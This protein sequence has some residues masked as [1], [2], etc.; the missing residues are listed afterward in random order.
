MRQFLQNV[1]TSR[2]CQVKVTPSKLTHPKRCI[3][4]GITHHYHH[5]YLICTHE[6]EQGRDEVGQSDRCQHCKFVRESSSDIIP[7]PQS[8]PTDL[9]RTG[10]TCSIST[11]SAAKVFDTN[12]TCDLKLMNL[13]AKT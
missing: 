1:K 7:K 11:C 6:P 3:L 2:I 9:L 12:E 10:S 13:R 4:A 5:I 8:S